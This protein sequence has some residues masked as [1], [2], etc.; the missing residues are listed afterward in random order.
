MIMPTVDVGVGERCALVSYDKNTSIKENNP[1]LL[2]SLPAV[3]SS[4]GPGG[5]KMVILLFYKERFFGVS[6]WCAGPLPLSVCSSLVFT[7]VDVVHF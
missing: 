6:S 2:S 4:S 3:Y 5:M 7:R 1:G